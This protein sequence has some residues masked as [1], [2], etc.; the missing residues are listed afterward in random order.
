MSEEHLVTRISKDERI[1]WMRLNR[2]QKK[3]ALT[4]QMMDKMIA[5]IKTITE[6]KDISVLVLSAAGELIL[7]GSRSLLT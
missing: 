2:P 1:A 6:D 4:N 3:N 5:D 7:L